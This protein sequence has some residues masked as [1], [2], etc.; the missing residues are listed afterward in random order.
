M[1]FPPRLCENGVNVV[2]S[3]ELGAQM[4]R[5]IEGCDRGQKLLLRDCVD[6]Y[7][8]ETVTLGDRA[9]R[10]AIHSDASPFLGRD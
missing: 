1:R 2:D 3:V 7:V 10:L 4:S 5:F 6:D 8:R 9:V